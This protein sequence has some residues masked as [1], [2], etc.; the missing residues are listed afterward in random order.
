MAQINALVNAARAVVNTAGSAMGVSTVNVNLVAVAGALGGMQLS[1]YEVVNPQFFVSLPSPHDILESL[2][3]MVSEVDNTASQPSRYQGVDHSILDGLVDPN[4]TL[5]FQDFF[6]TPPTSLTQLPGTFHTDA[7][8]LDSNSL[9]DPSH[10]DGVNASG[11]DAAGHP[12]KPGAILNSINADFN[13]L[14][15]LVAGGSHV[16]GSNINHAHSNDLS[17][18]TATAGN[19]FAPVFSDYGSYGYLVEPNGYVYYSSGSG[20]VVEGSPYADTLFGSSAGGDTLIGGAGSDIYAVYSNTTQIIEGSN[21]GSHDTAYI[22]VDNYQGASGVERVVVLATQAYSDHAAVNGPYVAG[23]DSGWH[24]NGST[25]S[26]TLIGSYGA[27]ILNGEGGAD[28]LIG[29]AGDDVYIYTGSE[30]IIEQPNAGRDIVQTTVNL[31]MPANVEVGIAQSTASD[32]NITANDSGNLLVG[33]SASNTLT[34]GLGDDTLVGGGGDDVF[35]GGGGHNTFILNAQDSYM[36][37]ITDFHSG[38]DH[39]SLVYSDPTVTLSVAPTDGFSGV[40]GQVLLTD[41][42]LQVDWN[43]DKQFDSVLLVHDAPTLSDLS[44]IDTSHVPHF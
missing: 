3:S 1:G 19:N 5:N 17:T 18:N 28:T 6:F 32:L 23:I 29:G 13:S 39:I 27:D 42:Q 38:Q 26:Q 24:I 31:N 40:A 9:Y 34:G 43:G 30:T 7:L 22:G 25:D 37:E 2:A 41:G 15:S 4:A 33:N 10:P 16:V 20:D 36:G 14:D 11:P 12:G 44:V 35:S 21:G 8:L